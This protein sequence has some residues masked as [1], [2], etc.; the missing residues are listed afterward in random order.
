VIEI[1]NDSDPDKDYVRNVELYQK[2]PTILEY[3]LF[4][5]VD[6]V[7]GPTLRV[8][9]RDSGNQEWKID[10]YG[11]EATYTTPLLP[12]LSLPVSPDQD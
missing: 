6:E 12:S 3:W 2:V 1:V 8:Y 5:K 11:P 9:R 10:D 7:D 4:D